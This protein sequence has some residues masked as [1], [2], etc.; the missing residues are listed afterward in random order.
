[1]KQDSQNLFNLK[2]KIIIITGGSG[3]LGSE[4]SLALSN[5]GAIPVILD[6]NKTSLELLKGKIN[7]LVKD[8]YASVSASFSLRYGG[9][10]NRA[11]LRFPVK[12]FL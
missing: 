1:M 8:Y 6:I 11:G 12:E 2:N 10:W 4:F 3:F 7:K 9:I 5:V